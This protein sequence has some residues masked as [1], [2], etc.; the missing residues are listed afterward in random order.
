MLS[1][2][3]L[4]ILRRIL[5]QPFAVN[6]R[7]NAGLIGAVYIYLSNKNGNRLYD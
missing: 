2:V 3:W 6:N 7:A 4:D 5:G 1:E